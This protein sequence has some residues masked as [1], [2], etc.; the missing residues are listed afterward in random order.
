MSCVR[1][2]FQLGYNIAEH[3]VE[4]SPLPPEFYLRFLGNFHFYPATVIL[5]SKINLQH[6]QREQ[7][8]RTGW[9]QSRGLESGS[10]RVGLVLSRFKTQS[11][12]TADVP[13]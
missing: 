13:G 5:A 1:P 4:G 9:V 3:E 11:K 12:A 8:K 2:G 6:K 10:H 7:R